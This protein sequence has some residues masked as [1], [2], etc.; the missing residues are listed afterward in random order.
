MTAV[1]PQDDQYLESR[2][3]LYRA[4]VLVEQ[5]LAMLLLLALF[6]LITVQVTARYVFSS[7]I[8][9]TEE[10]A[11]FIFIWFTFA[12]ASFVAARRKHITVQLYGGGQT[13]KPVAVIE[14][15]AYLVMIAVSV[16]MV[17]GGF[18]MVQSTWN[19]GSPGTGLPYRFV[20]SALP[21][22]FA[23][24]AIHSALNLVLALRHPRQ[25]AGKPDIETAGL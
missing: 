18:L 23:L 22:G 11:R 12:A 19:V 4:L 25:F 13:G 2:S 14:A 9:G 21:V 24:V 1:M 5:S 20:Y 10:I 6:A 17:V 15:F 8:S 3:G 7:P 16:A